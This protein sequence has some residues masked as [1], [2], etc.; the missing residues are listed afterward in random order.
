MTTPL[1]VLGVCW[2]TLTSATFMKLTAHSKLRF[3]DGKVGWVC[4]NSVDPV[5]APQLHLI[6]L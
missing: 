3:Q 1:V 5:F 6:R 4:S 2:K